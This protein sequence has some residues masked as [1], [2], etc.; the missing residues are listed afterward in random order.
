MDLIYGIRKGNHETIRQANGITS[1]DLN[2]QL[3]EVQDSKVFC[4]AILTGYNENCVCNENHSIIKVNC[5]RLLASHN[6]YKREHAFRANY[7][8]L[9]FL[10]IDSMAAFSISYLKRIL[11][12]IWLHVTPQQNI[13][14]WLNDKKKS[15]HKR[16]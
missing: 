7:N 16:G 12:C 4:A 6:Q 3:C 15:K 11:I 13:K 2:L 1:K 10:F 14:H 9:H 8:F 5:S